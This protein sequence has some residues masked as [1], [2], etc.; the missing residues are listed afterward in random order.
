MVGRSLLARIAA[1]LLAVGA[2][3]TTSSGAQAA[4]GYPEFISFNTTP[5]QLVFNSSGSKPLQIDVGLDS[6]GD[7]SLV[8]ATMKTCGSLT[9]CGSSPN[10]Y[11]AEWLTLEGQSRV[12]QRHVLKFAGSVPNEYGGQLNR[13]FQYRVEVVYRTNY[14]SLYTVSTTSSTP[15]YGD[16][17]VTIDGPARITTGSALTLSGRATCFGR[18]AYTIPGADYGWA[19]YVDIQHREPGGAWQSYTSATVND[20]TAAIHWDPPAN[21][22]GVTGYRFGWRSSNGLPVP[23]WSDVWP[24][25]APDPLVMINLNPRTTYT[26]WIEAVT[27]RGAGDRGAVTITTTGPA[28]PPS[29]Q[30]NRPTAPRS[31]KATAGKRRVTVRWATPARNGG[32]AVDWYQV[33]SHTT[34]TRVT[35]K[36]K[37]VTFTRLKA[38]TTYRYS[39][40]AHN[41]AGWGPWTRTVSA[42]PRA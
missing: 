38:G 23:T 31:A 13:G 18:S 37:A 39:V 29:T 35:T 6:P 30:V 16:S 15:A 5:N 33:R 36:A 2:L 12:A 11:W 41:K 34:G 32:A 40:R 10:G 9:G 14:G 26:M 1:G 25:T 3:A 4:P 7:W 27:A 22:S 20:T 19:G 42:K 24:T 28:K 21:A 8:S 17:R